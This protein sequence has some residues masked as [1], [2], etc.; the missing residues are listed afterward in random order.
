VCRNMKFFEPE[1]DAGSDLR[2]AMLSRTAVQLRWFDV[3]VTP[4]DMSASHY[5]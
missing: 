3:A 1:S 4:A 5:S 2:G